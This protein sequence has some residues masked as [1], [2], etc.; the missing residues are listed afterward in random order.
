[1]TKI[2]FLD[3]SAQYRELKPE[4][5]E[6]MARVLL[7]CAFVGG[8]ELQA[9]EQSFAKYLGATSCIGVG[10]GTDALEIALEALEL[11]PGSEVIVPANSFIATAEA[12]TRA[13]HRVVFCDCDPDSYTLS[14]ADAARRV[15]A[16]TRAIIPVH[17]YGQPCDMDGVRQLADAH[18]LKVI[19]DCAQAH[20]AEFR[21]RKVGTFGEL[22][23]FS[24]YPG[25]NL[26]AYGDGGAI[27]SCDERLATRCRMIANHGR[28]AKYDHEFEGRNSRLDGLQAAVLRVKLRHL[29]RWTESRRLHAAHYGAL[30][31][32][33]PVLAPREIRERRH[34]YHLYVV[35]VEERERVQQKL[36]EAGIDSGVH[37]PIALPFLKAYRRLGHR[38]EDFPVAASY[39][40][41][42]L[43]LPLFPELGRQQIE[44]VCGVLHSLG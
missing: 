33:S 19:E 17:L 35:R 3:L 18:G 14:V 31:E 29:E 9:F 43:S 21:G 27:V 44:R 42:L 11:P 12:V 41:K 30:L 10:N 38:E 15:G 4:L 6:A 8:E 28:I 13:G 34:V 36:R 32:G 26:G 5:D 39:Q 20:G 1:M 2:P 16:A 25:K 22:A 37:Y 40:G 23:A 24:F 7:E